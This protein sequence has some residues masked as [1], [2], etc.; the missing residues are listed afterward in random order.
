MS[1]VASNSAKTSRGG[2]FLTAAVWFCA[3]LCA[4]HPVATDRLWWEL[5][6]GREFLLSGWELTSSLIAGPTTAEA[7]WLSGIIPYFT[8]EIVGV[9]GLMVLKLLCVIGATGLV[10]RRLQADRTGPVTPWSAAMLIAAILAGCRAWEPGPLGYDLWGLIVVTLTTEQA[11]KSTRWRQLLLLAFCLCLWANCGPRSVVG[12]LLGLWWVMRQRP[13]LRFI[14]VASMILLLATCLTPA[15]WRT[16]LDS[17]TVTVPQIAESTWVLTQAGWNPWWTSPLRP[18]ALAFLFLTLISMARLNR[19]IPGKLLLVLVGAQLLATASAENLPIAAFWLVLAATQPVAAIV[20]RK[21]PTAAQPRTSPGVSAIPATGNAASARF[22]LWSGIGVGV[23]AFLAGLATFPQGDAACGLGW[24]IDPSIQSEAFAASLGETP[25]K[26]TAHC[27]GWREA[28]LLSW[29]AAPRLKPFDTPASAL[30]NGRL[31][32]HVLLTSD[33]TKGW[34]VPHRRPEGDWGGWWE[35]IKSRRITALVIPSEN[36]EL[37]SALEPSLWKPLSL[38]AVSLLY[39]QAGDPG[40][41]PQIINTL[42]IRQLVDRGVWTYQPASENT[43]DL[44]EI[45]SGFGPTAQHYQRLRLARTFRA[46]Q[47]HIAALKVLEAHPAHL[48]GDAREEFHRN[49]MALGYRERI[50]CGRSSELRFQASLLT[51]PAESDRPAVLASLNWPS[52]SAA[53]EDASVLPAVQRYTSG[54][55]T[56]AADLLPAKSAEGLYGRALL[57]LERGDPQHTGQLLQ[58]FLQVHSTH[59]L[60]A[61]AKFLLTSLSG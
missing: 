39:G 34:Q 3:G 60:A 16:P 49:Q 10:R 56:G 58:Q 2:Q 17:L 30:L 9:S 19:P 41:T 51:L 43:G 29:Y 12:L 5:S 23:V 32:E 26:G 14:S 61:A 22:N 45:G 4:L 6:K 46:M 20:P 50:H 44:V 8:Y 38:S 13:D 7:T 57:S 53:T 1:R 42:A 40:C 55:L 25:W 52:S 59:P 21:E 27:V 36:L 24:G 48:N 37:V 28:G 31:R 35:T 54:D 18:D 47:L 15:G 33:L 11:A